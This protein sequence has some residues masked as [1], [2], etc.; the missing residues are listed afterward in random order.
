MGTAG[1]TLRRRSVLACVA[2]VILTTFSWTPTA[3]GDSGETARAAQARAIGRGLEVN[4]SGLSGDQAEASVAVA[5][6]KPRR[7]VTAAID[8]GDENQ[9]FGSGPRNIFISSDGGHNWKTAESAIWA[10][11]T[12]VADRDGTFWI[13]GMGVE[14]RTNPARP[15]AIRLARIAPGE[16]VV[17]ATTDLPLPLYEMSRDKPLISIDN[18]TSSPTYG[19]LYAVWEEF[20]SNGYFSVVLTY[21]DTRVEGAYVPERCDAAENWVTPFAVVPGAGWVWAPDVAVGPDGEVYVLW[22]DLQGTIRGTLC[23]TS[24][25]SAASFTSPEVVAHSVPPDGCGS[26]GYRVRQTPTVDVDISHGPNRG[27][28]YVSWISVN[29]REVDPACFY[30][31][32]GTIDAYVASEIGGLPG[33]TSGVAL[34]VDGET[35]SEHRV[36]EAISDEFFPNVA[37]DERTGKTWVSFYST[38]LDPAR[39]ASNVYVRR[40]MQKGDSLDLSVVTRVSSPIDFSDGDAFEFNY[41]DY[42][43]LDVVRGWPYPAWVGHG[44][45]KDIY[46]WIPRRGRT[47]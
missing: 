7:I 29:A 19:R 31:A 12:V 40:L 36:G 13:L 37:V 34:Y 17:A 32:V 23:A 18:S 41:G 8:F 24:C 6:G 39:R 44:Q 26:A 3:V 33:P 28:V 4:A 38:R 42:A 2:A 11:L 21:C 22:M 45:E 5:P 14:D 1:S 35:D 15:V 16:S 25:A 10:D 43:G 20:L 47:P 9:G 27:R 46:T 30:S